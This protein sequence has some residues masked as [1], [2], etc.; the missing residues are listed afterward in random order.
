[1]CGIIGFI[2]T[3]GRFGKPELQAQAEYMANVL[4]HR[5]PDDSGAWADEH[6]GS[7][8]P[9]GGWQSSISRK[10]AT[11]QCVLLSDTRGRRSPLR[12][13]WRPGRAVILRMKEAS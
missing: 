6:A 5:G 4:H 11:S 12:G 1:M 10:K 7:D 3:A 8:W 9:I 13:G 2:D